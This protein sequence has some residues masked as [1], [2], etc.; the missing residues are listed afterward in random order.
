M[1]PMRGSMSTGVDEEY[2]PQGIGRRN[3]V[4]VDVSDIEDRLS[5][6]E[7]DLPPRA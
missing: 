7:S 1:I 3:R 5:F 6:Y 2:T 4:E